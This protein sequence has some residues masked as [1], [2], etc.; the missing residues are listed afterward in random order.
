MDRRHLLRGLAQGALL[1]AAGGALVGCGKTS[2][3][4][5]DITGADYARG[6]SLPDHNGRLRTLKDFDGRV[7]V[8]FFGYTQCPDVCPTSMLELAEARRL[9]GG[10]GDRLQGLF[11]TLDPERD[12]P[13]I[14]K[15]YM[16]NF[17]PGF[18]ALIPPLAELPALAK[19][20]KVFYRKVE[21]PTPTSYTMDHSA[22]SYVFDP[23]GR[24][25]LY[26]RHAGGADKLA[27][28]V[29]LLLQGR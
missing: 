7:V 29:R 26:T 1:A 13:E 6:F 14:L 24:V 4:A 5:V 22:G 8:L 11:I 2:F 9:L 15:A 21:G 16:T 27:A 23:R 3:H 28:D 10:E 12:T 20:F 19:D 25:R 17:D 18:L